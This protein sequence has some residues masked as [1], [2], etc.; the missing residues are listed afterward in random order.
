METIVAIELLA[1]AQGID[2]RRQAMGDVQLGRGTAV[3]YNLLREHVPFLTQDTVLAPIM[4]KIRV[5]V[6]D[7][8]LK[9]AVERELGIG[10]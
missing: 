5:L 2:F 8:V 4:E 1:S 3:A 6:A 10:D 9:N 7:G